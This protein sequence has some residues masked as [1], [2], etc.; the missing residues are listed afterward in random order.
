MIQ[1][2][3]SQQLM[4]Q[5]QT[6]Q[7]D[8]DGIKQKLNEMEKQASTK[9][10]I[11]QTYEQIVQDR[12]TSFDLIPELKRKQNCVIF[13]LDRNKIVG[14]RCDIYGQTIHA[15]FAALPTQIF[16]FNTEAGPLYKDCASVSFVDDDGTTDY[17]YEYCNML[18]DDAD[19]S[20]QDV[21]KLFDGES[22]T[23]RV[24]LNHTNFYGNTAC[25]MIEIAPY[26][27]GTF[28]IEEIRIFSVTQYLAEEENMDIP[29]TE[30]G[31]AIIQAPMR[32]VGTC[33]FML[34]GE[35]YQ[36]YR[37]D[38][39]IRIHQQADGKYPFG[40][41]HIY[42][43]NAKMDAENDYAVVEITQPDR[44]IESIGSGIYVTTPFGGQNADAEAFNIELY[45]L[46]TADGLLQ[47]KIQLGTPLARN[48]KT[49]Y[50]K[51]PFIVD[52]IP[53]TMTS[54]CFEDITLR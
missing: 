3:N 44:Y 7:K 13:G 21:F 28:D 39:K 53:I 38:F 12:L 40:L 37:I 32:D 51:I 42:F 23:L 14:D 45:M 25:N 2:P 22:V 31:S 54:I 43:Y 35:T 4:K 24:Q 46:Y 36:I 15:K 17:K 16:N 20:K 9:L 18:K 34:N 5:F 27:P 6:M 11:L 8:V 50:A 1:K 48:L 19:I 33:R 49:V 30:H 26:L 10:T 47:N 29:S 41:R 52:N